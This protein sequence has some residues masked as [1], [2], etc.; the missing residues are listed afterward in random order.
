MY[1][2]VKNILIALVTEKFLVKT[3]N[4]ILC[5]LILCVYI[6]VCLYG[7]MAEIEKEQRQMFGKFQNISVIA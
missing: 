3:T 6:F 2:N 7:C 1:E 4:A 5:A